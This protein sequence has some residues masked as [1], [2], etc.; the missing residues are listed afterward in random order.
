[1]PPA[2]DQAVRE[3]C[4]EAINQAVAAL[5][6]KYGFDS[7]EAHRFLDVSNLKV[8][9]KRGPSSHKETGEKTT[10]TKSVVEKS[11]TKK[12]PTGYLLFG[13]AQRPVVKKELTEAL[14]E[15][16]KLKPQVVI[17]EIAHRWK[18][19][20]EEERGEWNAQAKTN[21]EATEEDSQ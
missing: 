11:K 4:G 16:E 14:E 3:M 13:A 18:A 7:E 20:S 9:R 17:T 15:G 10:K 6:E 2:F 1:M 12:S 8:V 5:A 21:E 19:L